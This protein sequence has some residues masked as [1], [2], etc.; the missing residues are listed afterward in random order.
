MILLDTFDSDEEAAFVIE[1]LKKN[2]IQ[3]SEKKGE[4]GFQVFINEADEPKINE[5]I[6]T[7]D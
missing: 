4:A 5:L 2:T 6:K 1:L 3:F 7:L